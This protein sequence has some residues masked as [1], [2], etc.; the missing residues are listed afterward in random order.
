MAESAEAGGGDRQ[1]RHF[2]AFPIQHTRGEHGRASG[3]LSANAH[4]KS[5]R[6][7]EISFDDGN[8]GLVGRQLL[9]LGKRAP[10]EDLRRAQGETESQAW[11]NDLSRFP[12]EHF[13]GRILDG[14]L[15]I[16]RPG[17]HF[18]LDAAGSNRLLAEYRS[19]FAP[20]ASN[21]I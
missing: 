2:A 12:I 3:A 7:A 18:E 8:G 1:R 20:P 15:E 11:H 5:I 13:S 10:A 9:P 4:K 17:R 6:A 21:D 19:E 16:D 14:N